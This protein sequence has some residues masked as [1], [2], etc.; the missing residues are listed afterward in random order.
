[1]VQLPDLIPQPA[2]YFRI[3]CDIVNKPLRHVEFFLID[4]DEDGIVFLPFARLIFLDRMYFAQRREMPK[5]IGEIERVQI[6][7]IGFRFGAVM[8]NE[9][10]RT[11]AGKLRHLGKYGISKADSKEKK[12]AFTHEANYIRREEF[13]YWLKNSSVRV[14]VV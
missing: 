2:K 8:Q 10:R 5:K 11:R 4:D 14:F 12:N 9:D 3:L 13:T 1:M 6:A 7:R